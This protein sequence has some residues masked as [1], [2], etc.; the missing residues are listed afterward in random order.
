MLSAKRES[1]LMNWYLT[2]FFLF[3]C[4]FKPIKICISIITLGKQAKHYAYEPA[5]HLGGKVAVVSVLLSVVNH[6]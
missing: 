1:Y 5:Y 4:I 6:T 2:F 3:C